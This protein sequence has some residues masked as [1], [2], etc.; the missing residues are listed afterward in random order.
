[1]NNPIQCAYHVSQKVHVSRV[2]RQ[3]G[4]WGRLDTLQE[5][6][7]MCLFMISPATACQNPRESQTAD[8]NVPSM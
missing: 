6:L 2:L 4:L 1:M 8:F 7:M 3:C 5:H